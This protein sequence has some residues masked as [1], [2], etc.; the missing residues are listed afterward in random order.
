MN[1]EFNFHELK[2]SNRLPSPSGTALEIMKLLQHENVKISDVTHLIKLDPALT[3]RILQFAN[4]AAVG[5]QRAISSIS[6]AIVILG[7]N[8]VKNFALSLSL[9]GSKND[10][11]CTNFDYAGY[12][13]RSLATAVALAA[14]NALNRDCEVL[15]EAFTFG[16]LNEIGRLA[17]ATAW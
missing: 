13:S 7:L 11:H 3:G 5:S 8:T 4:S 12:W 9:I 2:A 15:E 1:Q 10:D 17:L 6:D 16:L 14:L